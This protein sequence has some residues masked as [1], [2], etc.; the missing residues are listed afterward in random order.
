LIA[1]IFEVLPDEQGRER[2]LEIAADL[3]QQLSQ[4]PGFVSIERFQSL[5]DP[6]KLLSLS[7]WESEEAIREW[8]TLS[9]H[10]AAQ[11]AGRNSLFLDY[12]IRVGHI[13]RDYSLHDREQAPSDSQAVHP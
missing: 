5:S 1:V 7:F 6:G 3:R 12:R 2:Y 10:R 9:E 11:R 13:V 8:R 4:V